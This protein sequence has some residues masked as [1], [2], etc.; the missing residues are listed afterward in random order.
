MVPITPAELFIAKYTPGCSTDAPIIDMMATSD[1]ISMP[2][3]PMNAIWFSFSIIFGV[4]PDEISA[5]QPETEP[6]AMVINRNGKRLPAHTGP[7]PSINFVTDG[8]C[9]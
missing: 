1:S 2:P 7:V 9:R 4:V 6:Q 5:C 8:I 3:Y